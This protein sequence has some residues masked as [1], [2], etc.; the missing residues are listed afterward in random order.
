MISAMPK[1]RREL[2]SNSIYAPDGHGTADEYSLTD[3]N[4]SSLQSARA[5]STTGVKRL[6]ISSAL[7]SAVAA[8]VCWESRMIRPAP[9]SRHR[10]NSTADGPLS[11]GSTIGEI[12]TEVSGRLRSFQE[13]AQLDDLRLQLLGSPHERHP[14]VISAGDA[15]ERFRS[16]RA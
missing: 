13:F 12:C 2:D 4:E 1:T 10:F 14:A 6:I 15:L 9:A 11:F 7:P 3:R 5:R 8:T 16:V